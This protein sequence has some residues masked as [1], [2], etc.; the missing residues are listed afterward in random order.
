MTDNVKPIF[1][2]TLSAGNEPVPS[3]IAFIKGLLARAEHGDLRAIAVA[4][5][6]GNQRPSFGWSDEDGGGRLS[7]ILHSGVVI[8][9]SEYTEAHREGI[10]DSEPPPV[11][12]TTSS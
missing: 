9:Q 4:Y 2:G 10:I 11:D 3:V 8:L 7:F 6:R 5:V 12:Q 1:G